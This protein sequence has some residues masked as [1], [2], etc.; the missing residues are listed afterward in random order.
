MKKINK[1]KVISVVIT[2]MLLCSFFPYKS[3]LAEETRKVATE[4]VSTENVIIKGNFKDGNGNVSENVKLQKFKDN[5]YEGNLKLKEGKYNFNIQINGKV[6]NRYGESIKLDLAKDSVVIFRVDIKNQKVV[7]SINNPDKFKNK[8]IFVGNLKGLIEN[9]ADWSPNDDKLKLDYVGGGIYEKTFQIKDSAQKYDYNLEYKVSYDG[10]WNNGEVKNNIKYTVPKGSKSIKITSDYLGNYV[11]STVNSSDE[12]ETNVSD[13]KFLEITYVRNDK[14]YEGWNVW[15]WQTGKNDGQQNFSEVKDGKAVAKFEISKDATDVGFVIR[16]GSDWSQKDSYGSDRYIKIDKS[17]NLTKVTVNEGV[18]DIIQVP[19][20]KSAE[21]KDGAINFKYR[22]EES[23]QKNN[24]SSIQKVK[25]SVNSLD[26]KDSNK[27]TYDMEYDSKGEFYDFSL[28]DIK[29]GVYEYSF[30]VTK[31]GKTTETKKEKIEYSALDLNGDVTFKSKEVNCNENALLNLKLRG[32]DAKK[33]NIKEIYMDLTSVGGPSKVIMDMNLLKDGVISESFGIS[34]K[35]PA[36]EKTIQVTIVDKDGNKHKSLGKLTVNSNVLSGPLDFGFDESRIYFTVTDRFFNG[37]KGNDDPHKNNY[38]KKNPF[39]YHGG[40]LKGLKEKVPYLK[41][42]GINTIWITPIVENTDI[43]QKFCEGQTQYSYHGYWAKDFET[44]DP[45][46]GTLDDL[47]DLIDTAHENGIKIMVDVVLNHAG[48]GM[49]NIDSNSG[50]NN[51]P[52]D[53]DREKFKGM[54]RDYDGNDII[55][56]ESAGLPDFKTENND[57]R[58]KLIEWQTGWINR[59]RTAKGNAIDY[60]RVDTVKHVDNTTWKA[61]KNKLTEIDPGF[62][63]IGEYFGADIYNDGGQL[64]NGQMDSLLDFTYK[65]NAKD[66]VNGGLEGA[67]KY[68]DGRASKIDNTSLMGQFLS[69]H[70]EDGF[71]KTVGDDLGKQKVAASLQI[72]DKGMPVIYYGEELGMSGWNG[73]NNN[74]QNRYDMDFGRLNDD[75]YKSMHEHYKKLLNIRK[76][77]SKV[78]S[79]GDRK[80]IIANDREGYAV[81]SRSYNEEELFVALNTTNEEKSINLKTNFKEGQTVKD[82]YNGNQYTIGKDGYIN[83]K[84]PSK[85]K[86]GTS[87]LAIK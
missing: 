12:K 24:I 59:S 74:D 44:L 13:R 17:M 7:D 19:S 68:L 15:T 72:T 56:Q 41:E 6:D 20:I 78:F 84:I 4:N 47:K 71:L 65:Y 8:A 5:L 28:N 76:E 52:T 67:S 42:L 29:P 82:L 3:V 39:T 50:A 75:R 38:D 49:K 25:V 61:F 54:F 57:V 85:D 35:V 64:K 45:H 1:F 9:A 51:Y 31:D 27:K 58:D 69:S 34:D 37:D 53:K 43:N 21:I 23:Y 66:F 70:D 79:K 48:Y 80:T 36:G 32:N 55:T 16:K 73:M 40:D 63:T 77:Y 11:T 60:F 62:K 87:I 81:I 86:G 26:S 22:D 83:I 14:N 46:L 18:G 30:L 33:D 10:A 2:V